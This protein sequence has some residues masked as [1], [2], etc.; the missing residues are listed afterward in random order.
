MY[1]LIDITGYTVVKMLGRGGFGEV[2]LAYKHATGDLVAI[3]VLM[4]RDPEEK[5]RFRREARILREIRHRNIIAIFDTGT[6]DSG[7][8]FYEMEYCPKGNLHSLCGFVN[9][10]FAL[11][12]MLSISKALYE[13]HSAGTGRGFHRDIKPE[14]ILVQE[15]HRGDFV[16]KLADFG[17]ARDGNTSS[18]FTNHPAGTE[19]YAAPEVVKGG[20]VTQAADI[21]SLGATIFELL[22]GDLVERK[23]HYQSFLDMFLRRMRDERPERR[24]DISKVISETERY[25]DKLPDEWRVGPVE[26]KLAAPVENNATATIAP[27]G[28][29][30]RL[31]IPQKQ[32]TK[33]E[34]N[35]K[36]LRPRIQ[37]PP[38]KLQKD[39]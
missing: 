34:M 2:Y 28:L 5:D 7:Q 22:H 8:A 20:N 11:D 29:A 9:I 21:Y 3:K 17:F 31:E 4:T 19:G 39:N 23:Y 6:T 18:V 13:L 15:D 38:P 16:F 30:P 12:A 32:E 27:R 25:I 35:E 36:L 10:E 37:V 33:T 1:D 26:K 24:P 14:N